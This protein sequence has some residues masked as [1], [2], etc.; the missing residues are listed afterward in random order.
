MTTIKKILLT[1]AV[2]AVTSNI[3]AVTSK[4]NRFG[5]AADLIKGQTND[6]IIDSNGSIQ[7]ANKSQIIEARENFGDVWLVNSL[8]VLNDDTVY[9]GTSP[10][11]KIFRVKGSE[12]TQIYPVKMEMN[13]RDEPAEVASFSNEH[14]FAMELEKSGTVLAALSGDSPRLLRIQ[15]EQVTTVAEF[16]GRANIYDIVINDS[17]IFLATGPNGNIY[18]LAAGAKKLQKVYKTTEKN[19]LS[20]AMGKDGFLYAG[21]DR[22][23]VV[24]KINPDEGAASILFDSP[25][26][27]ITSLAFD[28][29][30]NLYAAATSASVV[31]QAQS[32]A[33]ISAGS[34]GGRP[35]QAPSIPGGGPAPGG[36][37]NPENGMDLK[38]ANSQAPP[39]GP[40]QGGP[41]Q[42]AR[43]TLPDS[44]SQVYKIDE[45]G[46]VT[47]VF[48][49]MAV[50]FDMKFQ[51]NRLLLGTGNQARLFRISP[52][53]EKREVIYEDQT[54]SQITALSVGENFACVGTSNPPSLIKIYDRFAEKGTYTSSLVDAGQP[55]AWGKLHL[56]ANIPA[57]TKV[58]MSAR[59]G[60]VDDPN[61]PT[62]SPWT[63]PVELTDATEL[64]CPMGRYCQY[65][66]KL[67]TENPDR[68]PLIR[69]IALANMVPNLAPKVNSITIA[70]AKENKEPGKF[71]IEFTA[72]DQNDD[73]LN[74]T[75]NFKKLGFDRWVMLQEDL[76]QNN[77]I[78]NTLTVPDGRY[79]IKVIA[80][81]R[82]S[83]TSTTYLEGSRISDPVVVDNTAPK[84]ARANVST[85]DSDVIISLE[86]KDELTIIGSVDY[87]VNSGD[88]WMGALPEDMIYDS[89]E[90]FVTIRI[91]DLH[92]GPH[93]IALKISDDVENT[94]YKMFQVNIEDK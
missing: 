24:Y 35:E 92:P 80:D 16:D 45:H 1:A 86:I 44:A 3:M 69:E 7:L 25:Q 83:N 71:K 43:G 21:C 51:N 6:T 41:A 94:A 53:T 70:P 30:G 34:P 91:E 93:V 84:V 49:E 76:E 61:D 39:P 68:T 33:S 28:Q 73:T 31:D 9:V 57:G 72:E 46:F 40:G 18:K 62:F 75:L 90:E 17:E 5:A 55:S 10:N 50:F 32:P 2:F 42:A 85:Q 81:D 79:E 19:V 4:I 13:A 64:T 38:A 54:A 27:E 47:K 11:G 20:L 23:G 67:V 36:K 52:E 88:K 58:L 26:E 89:L 12:M 66:L 65:R 37:G 77:Y 14:V 87:T 56:D 48:S 82:K 22:R 59:S 8:V 29:Q 74:Y 60:N 63:Q 15:D 78:W